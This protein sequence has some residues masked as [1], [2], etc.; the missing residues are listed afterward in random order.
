MAFTILEYL[1]VDKGLAHIEK[2]EDEEGTVSKTVVYDKDVTKLEL[3]IDRDTAECK[4]ARKYP[5]SYTDEMI[6]SDFKQFEF[7]ILELVEYD[8][9][10][11]G[12]E[13]SSSL[14]ENGITRQWIDRNKI[15]AK[16]PPLANYPD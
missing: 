13:N 7:V 16:I 15:L 3:L 8:W 4:K 10:Q 6:E 2:T 14:S 11:R 12:A 5:S 1:A 9:G